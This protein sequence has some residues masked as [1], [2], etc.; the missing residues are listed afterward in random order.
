MTQRRSKHGTVYTVGSEQTAPE[1]YPRVCA[2]CGK[3]IRVSR[4]AFENRCDQTPVGEVFRSRHLACVPLVA[5]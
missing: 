4:E 2:S 1:C 3:P 5:L